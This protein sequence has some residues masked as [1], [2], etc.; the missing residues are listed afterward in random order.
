VVWALQ[1]NDLAERFS[2]A[3]VMDRGRLAEQGRFADLK[4]GG[5]ALS[6]LLSAG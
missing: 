2:H 6:K 1:R 3:L 4:G 5:G